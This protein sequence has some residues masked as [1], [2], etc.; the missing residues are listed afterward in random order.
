MMLA[1]AAHLGCTSIATMAHCYSADKCLLC[2]PLQ[3]DRY[4]LAALC[5]A[6]RSRVWPIKWHEGIGWAQFHRNTRLLYRKS[7]LL[8]N[9]LEAVIR[10]TCN[11]LIR[12]TQLHASG[13]QAGYKQRVPR[14]SYTANCSADNGICVVWCAANSQI[15]SAS[16]PANRSAMSEIATA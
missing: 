14:N 3:H 5:R 12:T 10:H 7:W 16:H 6:Q 2:L 11:R 15:E 9:G 4:A 13:V 1:A 8:N